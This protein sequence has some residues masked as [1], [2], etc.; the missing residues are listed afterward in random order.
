MQEVQLTKERTTLGRRPD[1]DVVMENMAVSGRHACLV[2]EDQQV[3]IEDLGSTNGTYVNG[4]AVKRQTLQDG[5][6]VEI[7]TFKIKFLAGSG[8]DDGR[9]E[10]QE[11]LTVNASLMPTPPASPVEPAADLVGRIKVLAGPAAG[12]ELPLTKMVTTFGKP[13]VAVAAI[14]RRDQNYF[15][16]LVEGVDAPLLNGTPVGQEPRMLGEGDQIT[17]SGTVLQFSQC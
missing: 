16:H 6:V 11:G 4:S 5:D 2:L 12:R 15:V 1:C 10:N 8:D 17:L 9:D 13:G 3:S 7:G 14:T